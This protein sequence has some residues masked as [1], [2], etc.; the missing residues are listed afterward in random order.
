MQKGTPL[1]Q[2]VKSYSYGLINRDQY[3]AIRK[4]LLNKLSR[5]GKLDQ[6]DFTHYLKQQQQSERGNFWSSYSI[7][8]WI[9]IILGLMAVTILAFFLY[10]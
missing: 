6:D 8:D 9:I 4:Q 7:S 5:Q 2:L 3:L 1:K 10:N